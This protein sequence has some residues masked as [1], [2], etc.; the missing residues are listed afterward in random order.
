MRR[1]Q[2]R[3]GA[4]SA[5]AMGGFDMGG[6]Q[7]ARF[8]RETD[9]QRRRTMLAALVCSALVV[10]GVLGVVALKVHQVR[11]SY[12]LDTLRTGKSALEERGRLLRVELATLRSL[13]RIED[14]ART[15]LGMTPPAPKQV[16]LARE[17]VTSGTGVSALM[18]PRTASAERPRATVRP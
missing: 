11:L 4:V 7:V 17:F 12:R 13:A 18:P 10:G 14:K 8:H 15:E 5:L 3:A 16:Q 9:R 2:V 1:E 6:Q